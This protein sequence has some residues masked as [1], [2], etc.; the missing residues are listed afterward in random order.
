MGE[1]RWDVT[2]HNLSQAPWELWVTSATVGHWMGGI[3]ALP[4]HGR[5][6]CLQLPLQEPMGGGLD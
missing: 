2:G 1:D 6:S 5:G 3:Q 4:S